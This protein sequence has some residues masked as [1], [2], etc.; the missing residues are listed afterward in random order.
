MLAA[1]SPA[2]KPGMKRDSSPALQSGEIESEL[3]KERGAD[4]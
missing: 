4:P 1:N 3:K 2:F